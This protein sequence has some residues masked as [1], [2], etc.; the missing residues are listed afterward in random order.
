MYS[1]FNAVQRWPLNE[2]VPVIHSLT[3]KSKSASGNTIA[4]F[5]ASK[6]RTIRSRFFFGWVFC[7]ALAELLC[8]IS[9]K[10]SIFPVSI[11][12]EAKVRPLPNKILTTPFGKLF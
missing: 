12:G 6:P 3:A 4:G 11:I 9:A 7:N 2:R 8:P 10:T 5:F 1:I